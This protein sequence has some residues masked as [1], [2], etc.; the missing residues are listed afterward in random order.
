MCLLIYMVCFL[1]FTVLQAWCINGIHSCFKGNMLV[2]GVSGKVD[3]QG[4][5]FYMMAPKFFESNKN[6]AWSKPFFSCVMCMASVWGALTF[7]PLV[8]YLFG[9][10]WLELYVFGL[11]VFILVYLNKYFYSKI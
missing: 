3:Y 1:L 9:F 2:D 5:V 8:I 4:M 11:D 6:K 7:W 10:R